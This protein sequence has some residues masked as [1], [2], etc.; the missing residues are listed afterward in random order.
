MKTNFFFFFFFLGETLSISVHSRIILVLYHSLSNV[1][2]VSEGKS[3]LRRT[4][5][6]TI[7][8]TVTEY[9]YSTRENSLKYTASTERLTSLGQPS[10]SLIFLRLKWDGLKVNECFTNNLSINGA[11]LGF[12]QLRFATLY[13]I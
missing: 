13:L 5:Y 4:D 9:I 8:G 1:Y 12:I 10:D 3:A 11:F 2:R 7:H 6:N